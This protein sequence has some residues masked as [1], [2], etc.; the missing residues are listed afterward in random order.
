MHI[1]EEEATSDSKNIHGQSLRSAVRSR[2]EIFGCARLAPISIRSTLGILENGILRF[3]RHFFPSFAYLILQCSFLDLS[4]FSS[5]VFLEII[6]CLSTD[7]D[8][9]STTSGLEL[10]LLT[11]ARIMLDER[12]LVLSPFDLRRLSTSKDVLA[13]PNNERVSN[14]IQL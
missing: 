12:P 6:V 11:S 9:V 5:V 4:P 14:S 1:E 3:A 2:I 10:D 7:S 13:E 8:Y